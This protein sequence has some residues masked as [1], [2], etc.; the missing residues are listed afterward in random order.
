M[1]NTVTQIGT[2]NDIKYSDFFLENI[3]HVEDML[4]LWKNVKSV[5][6][7]TVNSYACLY[8]FLFVLGITNW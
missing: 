2:L 8:F 1:Q 5:H 3:L 6:L 7:L 4:S